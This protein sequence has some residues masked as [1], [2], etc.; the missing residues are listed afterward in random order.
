MSKKIVVALLFIFFLLTASGNIDSIDATS[1]MYLAKQIVLH[2]KIDYGTGVL[3]NKMVAGI[4]KNDGNRYI[5]YN[6]GYALFYIP[7]ILLSEGVREYLH[8]SPSQFPSQP[9]YILTWYANML[10]GIVIVRIVLLICE[11][12]KRFHHKTTNNEWWL[13]LFLVFGTNMVIQGH[14][15]FA[16]P[17]FTLFALLSFLKLWDYREKGHKKDIVLFSVYMTITATLYNATF[18]LLIIPL[19]LYY[20]FFNYYLLLSFLPSVLVQ[21]VWNYMRYGNPFQMGYLELGFKIYEFNPIENI[22]NLI[23]MTIGPNIGLLFNN[24]LLI[25]SY[26]VAMKEAL[27]KKSKYK[28]FSMFYLILTFFYVFNYSLATIWHGESTY[29]PRYLFILV[30]LGIPFIF[31][32]WSKAKI[33][34]KM[35]VIF[36]IIIGIFVQIPGLLI[37]HFTFPLISKPYCIQPNYRYF[38]PRCSPALV[39]WVQLLKRET[40][41]T[42]LIFK[43]GPLLTEKYPNPLTAF[44]TLYPDPLFNTFSRYKTIKYQVK[45]D[46]FNCVY[47]FSLDLWW[48]K[49]LYYENI[50]HL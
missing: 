6:F 17:I 24:P 9:D 45:E 47:A 21:L 46:L 19:I 8:A 15:Q 33:F 43:Q 42:P 11:I 14:H 26:I 5:I 40:R 30:P 28:K 18:V 31:L 41:E 3:A 16:H 23:G 27:K 32:F 37:P 2:G 13:L 29:G 36:L 50:P 12:L 7:G 22:K 25:I 39:G 49:Q 1:H 4:N 38:D 35:I 10:N 34:A 44:R 48:I 20:S